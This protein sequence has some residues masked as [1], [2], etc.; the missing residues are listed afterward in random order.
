MADITSAASSLAIIPIGPT[1][2]ARTLTIGGRPVLDATVRALRATPA[3]GPIVLAL[4]GVDAAD[5]LSAIEDPDALGV[6]ATATHA[7]RWQA[8]AAALEAQ[9]SPDTV[10]L[11]EPD[12]PL[13]T[14]D[15]IAALLAGIRADGAVLGLA[16]HETVKRVVGGR[17][18]DTVPRETVHVLQAPSAFRRRALA[19]ATA[20][21]VA[22]RWACVDELQLALA[23]GL[24]VHLVDGSRANL[25]ILSARDARYAELRSAAAEVRLDAAQAA[26]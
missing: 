1:S 22:E 19:A 13:V 25:A 15:T 8:I 9:P 16:V 24:R 20:R 7:S 12:R 10:V 26:S 11:H 5:C 3:I 23:A 18:V 14:P 4:D 21:A 17:V 6:T 2:P